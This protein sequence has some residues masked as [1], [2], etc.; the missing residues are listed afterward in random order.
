MSR[1]AISLDAE[2]FSDEIGG[3]V[4]SIVVSHEHRLVKL[5]QKL[6]WE[7]LLA[8]VLPDL[9]RTEKKRRL[10]GSAWI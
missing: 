2:G 9:Q 4:V 8:L 7:E 5:S 6:P 3:G 1:Q 10:Y